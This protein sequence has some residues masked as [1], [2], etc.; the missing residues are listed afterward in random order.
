MKVRQIVIDTNVVVA[1]LLSKRG[2]SHRLLRLID[3]GRFEINVSVPLVLEYEAAAKAKSDK[4]G[5]SDADVDDIIDY[6]CRVAN[7]RQ[8][9]YLWRPLLKDPNDDMVLELAVAAGCDRIVTYN[10]SDFTGAD[11]FSVKVVTALEFLREIGE[12]P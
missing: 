11:R 2:A 3:K 7:P 1:A 12:I 4:T 9:F 5:L 6:I 8:I 10:L